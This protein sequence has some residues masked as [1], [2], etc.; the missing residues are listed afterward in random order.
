MTHP[1]TGSRILVI[2]DDESISLGL[3]MNLQAEGHEV[4][5]AEDG[6]A[7]PPAKMSFCLESGKS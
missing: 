4:G 7:T 2:E 3:Q 5:L 1:K 6:P